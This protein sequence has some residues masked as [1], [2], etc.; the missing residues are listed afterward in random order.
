MPKDYTSTPTLGRNKDEILI[1]DCGDR[2]SLCLREIEDEKIYYRPACGHAFC[3]PCMEDDP[4]SRCGNCEKEIR[5]AE[6]VRAV[7]RNQVI[8]I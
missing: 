6:P 7:Q 2:C 8:E 4:P 5:T 1:V 3:T